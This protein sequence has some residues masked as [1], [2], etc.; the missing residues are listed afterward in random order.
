MHVY[1]L[2]QAISENDHASYVHLHHGNSKLVEVRIIL[3]SKPRQNAL[4]SEE[5]PLFVVKKKLHNLVASHEM[6]NV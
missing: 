6:N 3:T 5:W 2:L 1:T 4:E